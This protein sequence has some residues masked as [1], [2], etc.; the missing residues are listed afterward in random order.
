MKQATFLSENFKQI[1]GERVTVVY[2][3]LTRAIVKYNHKLPDL[4]SNE[5]RA[6]R[7]TVDNFKIDNK[8]IIQLIIENT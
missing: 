3:W 1:Y 4:N 6:N 8:F 5:A 7:K 2:C